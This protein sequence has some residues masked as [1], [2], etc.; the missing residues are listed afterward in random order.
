MLP[1]AGARPPEFFAAEISLRAP[2]F[3]LKLAT[4]SSRFL[5][6][7][8]AELDLWRRRTNLTGPF[9]SAELVAHALESVLAEKLIPNGKR[10]VDI[11]SGGGLPGVPLAI[12]RP[13]IRVTLL[14]PRKKRAAFLTHLVETL[15]LSNAVVLQKRAQALK[16]TDFDV[17]AVRAVG[18]LADTLGDAPFLVS[19]GVFLVWTTRPVLPALQ[20]ALEGRFSAGSVL[21]IPSS[22]RR[23][24]AIF[25]KR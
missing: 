17:A 23:V 24:I 14:E 12:A 6:S 3:G 19:G 22:Q 5:A 16:A 8:L 25:R 7:Y 15:P 20:E 4:D 18:D 10:L 1:E 2:A 21:R 11:G 13:D 9:E